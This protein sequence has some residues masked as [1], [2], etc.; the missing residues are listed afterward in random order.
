MV[1]VLEVKNLSKKYNEFQLKNV[2]F[3]LPQG[4]IMGLV[5]E[6]GAGKS[7]TIKL[8][9]NLIRRDGGEVEIFGK[10]NLTHE[11][12][13]KE[14]LGVVFDESNFPDNMNAI[15]ISLMMKN[16]YK[17][18]DQEIFEGYLRRFALVPKKKVKD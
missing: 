10:D 1:N 12:E 16:V 2:K 7:T 18:W 4:C 11:R 8:L 5:G 14:D 15:D 13:I 9:L 3:S 17:N 6:N